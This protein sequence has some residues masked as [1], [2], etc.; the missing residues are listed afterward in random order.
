MNYNNGV[1]KSLQISINN[2]KY[3]IIF[4]LSMRMDK[5]LIEG[6]IETIRN[7]GLENEKIFNAMR[8]VPR[9]M[10]VEGKVSLEEA[11]GDF[12]V[13]IGRGQT[14]SQPFT[15]AFMLDLV[16]LKE[17]DNVLEI[18]TGSGWNA[19]LIEQIVGEEGRVTTVEYEPM[20]AEK[21]SSF[22]NFFGSNVQVVKGDASEGYEPNAKYDRIIV[23]C[24]SPHIMGA[25]KEQLK[26][27][28]I[29]VLPEGMDIQVMVKAIKRNG[30]LEREKHGHFSFVPLR[31]GE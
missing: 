31:G 6:M 5:E 4:L 19:A 15:V 2:Y 9:R 28:G 11:Y 22:L 21:A 24:A 3:L 13:V 12:P 23:T 16:E 18:G 25:W 10:F 26:E 27:G 8:A 7:Y 1:I 14:I 30:K 17:G 20:L 29:I